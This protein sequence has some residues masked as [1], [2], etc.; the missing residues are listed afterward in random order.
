MTQHPS[1][2]R[3]LVTVVEDGY[4]IWLWLDERVAGFP[5]LARR[6]LGQRIVAAALDALVATIEASLVRRG[7]S[8]IERLNDANRALTLLRILLRGARDR[9][10][11]S[12]S[13][14]EHVMREIDGWGRQ[15]GG[16]LRSERTAAGTPR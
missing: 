12:V 10:H 5:V 13:Q 1:A 8:R 11:L 3:P 6:S 9:K 15:L 4:R 14:H 7:S 16:L 2:P